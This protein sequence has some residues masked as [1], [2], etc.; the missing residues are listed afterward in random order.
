MVNKKNTGINMENVKIINHTSILNLLNNY[1]AMPR[2][3]IAKHLNL[4]PSA[5][6]QMC[7][8]MLE[9]DFIMEKG[10]VEEEKRAGRK[11][12][13]VDINYNYKYI[14]GINIEPRNSY[15][16]ITDLKAN[17]VKSYK[18]TTDVYMDAEEFIKVIAN[19][20]K[21]LMWE[22]NISKNQILGIGIGI[23][24]T[25]DRS[26]GKSNRAF[27][28]WKHEVDIKNIME[29][30]LKLPV[31]V[32]N[33]VKCFAEA[34]LIYGAGRRLDNILFV[35]WGPGVGSAILIEN[36]IYEGKDKKAAEIGHYIVNKDGL[37]CRCGRIGCLET[38]VSSESIIKRIKS[39]FSKENTPKLF[40]ELKGNIEELTF[41]KFD[42]LIQ[43]K[44]KFIIDTLEES[45]E[46]FA[47]VIVNVITI[48]APNQV[49]IFGDILEHDLINKKFLE[50]CKYYDVNYDESYIKKSNVGNKIKYI[51][52]IALVYNELFLN[53]NGI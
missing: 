39:I 41:D 43:S 38:I 48:L 15:I 20:C 7:N 27:G 5:V 29:N 23:V 11:K 36:N 53:K 49:I 22:I 16:T 31:I 1:G 34:E 18:I 9:R 25:V 26:T 19:R 45:I 46:C 4:T 14:L 13:L 2:K 3:D 33:N 28:I 51:G 8:D 52:P 32:E 6:T 40:E 37:K 47:R 21:I 42:M 24:G 30:E 12:I 10:E 17:V 35:K 44:D 50:Y